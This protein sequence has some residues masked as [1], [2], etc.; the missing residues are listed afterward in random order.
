[1]RPIVRFVILAAAAPGLAAQTPA[2]A[3]PNMLASNADERSPQAPTAPG[4]NAVWDR[5]GQIS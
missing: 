5:A 4:L 1:M 3:A 2:V